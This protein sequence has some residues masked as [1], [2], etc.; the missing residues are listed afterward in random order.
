MAQ[1]DAPRPLTDEVA[2][3]LEQ[4][5]LAASGAMALDEQLSDRLHD[6]LA[7]PLRPLLE[8]LGRPRP[9][10]PPLRQRLELSLAGRRRHPGLLWSAAAAIAVLAAVG[11]SL[12][13]AA[14]RSTGPPASAMRGLGQHRAVKGP[15]GTATSNGGEASA[16][17]IA[18]PAAMPSQAPGSLG[19]MSASAA[20]PSTASPA[21]VVSG[22]SP[23][24]GP[25]GGGTW[26]VVDGSGLA[27][28]T[29]VDFGGVPASFTVIS[30]NSLRVKSP[31]HPSGTVDVRVSTATGPS[32]L[33]SGDRFTYG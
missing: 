2:S 4:S 12:G 1:L 28:A 7:D 11:A 32:P 13:I 20:P 16:S 30:E 14:T 10:G 24:A 8:D 17:T 15:T 25:D 18:R 22:L 9:L 6:A 26:I 33:S 21:P 31:P 29:A 19:P 3:R 5:L 27:A 23:A